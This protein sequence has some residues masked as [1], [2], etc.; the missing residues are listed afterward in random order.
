MNKHIIIAGEAPFVDDLYSLCLAKGYKTDVFHID[1]L[2]QQENLDKLV[3]DAAQCD[4]FIESLNESTASKLWLIEGVEVNLKDNALLLTNALCTSATEVASWCTNPR[5]VVGFGLLPPITPPCPLE[6]VPPLQA[7]VQSATQA[8]E[9]FEKLGFEIVRA[10]DAPGMV[11]MRLLC[12]LINE[13]VFALDQKI[14]SA[15]EIDIAMQ[16]SCHLPRG[17]L[18][19]ADEL[20][21]DVVLGVLVGM[22]DFWGEERYRPAPLLKQ[23]VQARHLGKKVGRGFFV[24]PLVVPPE[25]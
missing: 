8:R 22:Y 13:A 10:P 24:D 5:R 9:L 18:A 14:A 6:F 16:L 23:K 2:D 1:D 25:I 15:E 20:G 3:N 4:I 19:W 17:P 11:R 12:T 21:L 7:A